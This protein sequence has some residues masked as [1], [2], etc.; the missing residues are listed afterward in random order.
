MIELKTIQMIKAIEEEGSFQ[1]AADV[2]YLSQ[3]A[4]S[5][6]IKRVEKELSFNLYERSGGKCTLTE[7][8]EVLLEEGQHYLNSMKNAAKMKDA[9][10]VNKK[11]FSLVAPQDI[12]YR[13]LVTSFMVWS[14]M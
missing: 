6:Y 7:A 11:E 13:G 8:G 12:Q 4:L 5:Q 14:L 2:L 3:P 1:K 9:A 10:S